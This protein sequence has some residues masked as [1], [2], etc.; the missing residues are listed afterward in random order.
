METDEVVTIRELERA[1]ERAFEYQRYIARRTYGLYYLAW[2]AVIL[3]INASTNLS[4]IAELT[5]GQAVLESAAN[6]VVLF[7]AAGA[8]ALI[9]R[10]ARRTLIVNRALGRR[11]AAYAR[12]A[13]G[14]LLGIYVAVTA[15]YLLDH[16][17]LSSLFYAVLLSV[18]IVLYLPMRL[19]FS[20]RLPAESLIALTTYGAAAAVSLALSLLGVDSWAL[21]WVWVATSLVWFFASF[22]ALFLAPEELEALRG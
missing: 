7:A 17:Y 12:Y 3:F 14:L 4:A 22:Y 20:G 6:L 21:G 18:P 10:N 2:A 16:A 13:S 19:A 8:T 9:F 1:T 5:G 11:R 15:V